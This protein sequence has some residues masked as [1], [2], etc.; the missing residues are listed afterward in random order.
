MKK[1]I[2]C[3]I[4]SYYLY[5]YYEWNQILVLNITQRKQYAQ[6]KYTHNSKN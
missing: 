5:I 6:Y 4:K 3:A 1:T 2:Y